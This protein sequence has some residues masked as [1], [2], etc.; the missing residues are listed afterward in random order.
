M[1]LIEHS[2]N[3]TVMSPSPQH[4]IAQP[5]ETTA[6]LRRADFGPAFEWGVA[7]SAFQ[8]EG[9]TG[10]DGRGP[11]IWDTFCDQPGKI[12]DGS[13]GEIACDHYHLLE[14]DLA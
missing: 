11:S 10:A 14:Q 6:A 3:R 2:R 7:T 8:I 9:A 4:A 13:T 5:G 12:A 1:G